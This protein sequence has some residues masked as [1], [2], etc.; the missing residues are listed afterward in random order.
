[1]TAR[2]KIVDEYNNLYHRC[3]GKKSIDGDY[4]AMTEEDETNIE[5]PKFKVGD[6]VRT[7]KYKNIFSYS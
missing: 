5:A 6:G 3:I 7:S 4:Y 1:M 2:N